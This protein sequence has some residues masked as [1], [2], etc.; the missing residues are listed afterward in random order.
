MSHHFNSAAAKADGRLNLTDLYVFPTSTGTTVLVMNVGPDAGQGKSSPEAFHP[1]ATEMLHRASIAH[2]SRP[3]SGYRVFELPNFHECETMSKMNSFMTE[4]ERWDAVVKS[5]PRADGAF[6]YAVKTTG[7]Y[8]RSGCSS[9][10]P[11]QK[12]VTFFQ[13]CVE[14]EQAG[15]RPCKRCQPNTVSPREQQTEVIAQMCKRIEQS[16]EVGA[17]IAKPMALQDM[18][19]IAGLSP[20]HFHR[21]FKQIVG[22]TPKAYAVAHRAKR[23]REELQEGISVT[24]AIYSAGFETSSS[25]YD[26]S[27][28][29][30]GMT[31]TEYQQGA[32]GIEI[33]FA[34]KPVWLGWVLVAATSKGICTISLGDTA[35][36][37]TAQL[38]NQFPHAQ[39]LE[40]DPTFEN[41]IEQILALIETPQRGLN[42]P[43]DIQGT[44]FQQ[45]VWQALQT[46]APGNT[47]SY[48][49][50]AQQIGNPKAVRA[51]AR[52]CASNQ[53]AVAVPC[54]RV[55]GSDGSLRGYRWGND[56]KRALLEREAEQAVT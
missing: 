54:H 9:R 46:I 13:T 55:V 39:I 43:L 30:L 10:L 24:Q 7:I 45:R 42:L 16:V 49:T 29:M 4:A 41:W 28:R 1:H 3:K 50:I 6:L 18:A 5:D 21:L 15:F 37:L 19:E 33:Q 11:N 17:S 8:C 27:T 12:N 36:A 38:K 32:R 40:S 23:A 26:K 53:L 51:V 25:F 44:A 14:A 52:A 31:P 48:S 56:R 34:V 22:V 47:A 2:S 35:E 20:Y